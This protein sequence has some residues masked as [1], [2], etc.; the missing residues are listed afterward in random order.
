MAYMFSMWRPEDIAFEALD[1]LTDDP[2]VCVSI[3]TPIGELLVMAEAD[4]QGS[5][6]HL[7]G[8]SIQGASPNAVGLRNLRLLAALIMERLGYDELVIQ[9]SSRTTGAGPGRTPGQLRFAR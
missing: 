6:L 1:D 5:T 2:V 7:N 9:G 3:K 8:F 4:N